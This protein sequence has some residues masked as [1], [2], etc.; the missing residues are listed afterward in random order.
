MRSWRLFKPFLMASKC[1]GMQP[2]ATNFTINKEKIPIVWRKQGV[3]GS[4]QV[5]WGY[6]LSSHWGGI[7]RL[8][9]RSKGRHYSLQ[10]LNPKT[11]Y[12]HPSAKQKFHEIPKNDR[13]TKKPMAGHKS[14]PQYNS[15]ST[16]A[17]LKKQSSRISQYKNHHKHGRN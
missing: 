13:P 17:E 9:K 16:W 10:A 2:N 6:R 7:R 1:V 14:T 12:Q 5:C 4:G 11:N 8:L 3:Q 15:P